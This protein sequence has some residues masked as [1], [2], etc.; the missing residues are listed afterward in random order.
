MRGKTLLSIIPD[1]SWIMRYQEHEVSGMIWVSMF[2]LVV[3]DRILGPLWGPGFVSSNSSEWR[4]LYKNL[5]ISTQLKSQEGPFADLWRSLY[6]TL[7][8]FVFCPTHSKCIT[9]PVSIG[10]SFYPLT[11]LPMCPSIQWL[12]IPQAYNENSV[13]VKSWCTVYT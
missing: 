2:W 13:A 4:I 6:E 3:I 12:L 9:L 10:P 8:C 5:L 7:S 1:T 11:H